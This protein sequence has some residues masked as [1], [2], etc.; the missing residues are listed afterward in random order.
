MKEWPS[1]YYL[2]Q[3]IK[4]QGFSWHIVT[5]CSKG[6]VKTKN[7]EKIIYICNNMSDVKIVTL[8]IT[9]KPYMFTLYALKWNGALRSGQDSSLVS[10]WSVI[11]ML[12]KTVAN[13][14]TFKLPHITICP[15]WVLILGGRCDLSLCALDHWAIEASAVKR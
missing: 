13:Q 1:S 5:F 9:D 12:K 6:Y 11:W 4:Y 15:E 7:E 3:K 8:G 10:S 14:R 2:A